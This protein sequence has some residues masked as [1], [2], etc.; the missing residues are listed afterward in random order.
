M[1]SFNNEQSQY[2]TQSFEHEI[3]TPKMETEMKMAAT[4]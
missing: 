1:I 2:F 4:G 3:K